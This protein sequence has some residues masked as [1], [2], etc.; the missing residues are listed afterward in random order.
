[1]PLT[2]IPLTGD[3]QVNTTTVDIQRYAN[4]T[5]LNDGGF[6][7][8]WTSFGQDGDSAGVYAQRYSAT[9]T[10][11]GGEF[12]VNTTTASRQ[13]HSTVT[14]LNDGG[15]LVTW[16]SFGQDGNDTGIYAQR[17]NA[18]GSAVGGEFR[19]NA[20]TANNQYHSA[21]AAL[22]DGGFIVTWTS[23]AQDGN[24]GGIYAQRYNAA[25]ATVGGEFRV[26][27]QTVFEQDFSSVAALN[28]GGFLVTWASVGQD[29]PSWAFMRSA[30]MRPARQL[31]VNSV[32]IQRQKVSSCIPRRQP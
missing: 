30:T 13:M 21:S 12:R 26:N 8:T 24:N 19:V 32:S 11:V 31:A 4:V 22:D 18:A 3:I 7:V 2:P 6:L 14:A 16:D 15:F 27:T 29:G 25:G 20:T 23:F 1:M 5:A 9:G 10:A 28:D 17:Y